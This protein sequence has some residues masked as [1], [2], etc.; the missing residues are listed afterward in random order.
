VPNDRPTHSFHFISAIYYLSHRTSSSCWHLP[1]DSQFSISVHKIQ[2]V[3]TRKCCRPPSADMLC[4]RPPDLWPCALK[5][6][7]TVTPDPRNVHNKICFLLLNE[8]VRGVSGNDAGW[9]NSRAKTK[10]VRA[11]VKNGKRTAASKSITLLY[12]WEK[13]P[14]KTTE[15]MDGQCKTRHGS[16]EV[17][18]TT[19]NGCGVGQKQMEASSS[20]LSIIET[21]EESRR[22]ERVETDRRT[23][24]RTDEQ[25]L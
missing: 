6:G 24:G 14:R 11:C 5:I 17:D 16:K 13:E 23:D 12:Q 4:G 20:S 10:L 1:N 9:Q 22:E 25:D 8:T 15:E 21:M 19:S 18:C 7:T 2:Y 3:T